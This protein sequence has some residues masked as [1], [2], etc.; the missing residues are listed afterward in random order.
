MYIYVNIYIYIDI[1]IY[2]IDCINA[3]TSTQV[4]EKDV[5]FI[6]GSGPPRI[7]KVS[8]I[9]VSNLNHLYDIFHILHLI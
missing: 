8:S 9:D 1:D 7:S 2:D 6:S 4:L 5:S 3:Q